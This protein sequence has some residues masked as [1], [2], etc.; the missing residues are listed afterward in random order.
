MEDER[1]WLERAR[2]DPAEFQRLYEDYAQ[3]VRDLLRGLVGDRDVANDLADTTFAKALTGS[4]NDRSD[5][6]PP[7]I[8]LYGIALVE[9]RR[10]RSMQTRRRVRAAGRD[11]APRALS[12][13]D[14]DETT[15][16]ALASDCLAPL[17]RLTA[18]DR[19]MI[20]LCY[21][22]RLS[23]AEIALLLNRPQRSVQSRLTR[24]KNNSRRLPDEGD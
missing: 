19:V 11:G 2:R 23:V 8:C 10:H 1:E 7:R 9:A 21:W 14:R 18:S 6:L 24:A 20:C 3:D 12:A 22:G 17:A 15:R 5:E 13:G 4:R 16:G